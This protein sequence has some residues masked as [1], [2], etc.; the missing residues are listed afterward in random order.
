LAD[1]SPVVGLINFSGLNRYC[2]TGLGLLLSGGTGNGPV[3]AGFCGGSTSELTTF[4]CRGRLAGGLAILRRG[5]PDSRDVVSALSFS[6]YPVVVAKDEVAETAEVGIVPSSSLSSPD[7]SKRSLIQDP[8]EVSDVLLEPRR[9]A[10]V[11]SSGRSVPV[12]N[13]DNAGEVNA[14]KGDGGGFA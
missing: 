5:D 14:D 6:E 8:P 2:N 4:N 10:S 3:G 11:L 13:A 1:L 7:I 9:P 12:D